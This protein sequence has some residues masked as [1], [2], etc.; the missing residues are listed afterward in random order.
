MKDIVLSKRLATAEEFIELRQSVGW[1]YPEKE[2]ISTGL[3]N[4]LFSVCAEIDGKIIGHGRIIGD[5]SFALYI[6]DIIIKPEYQR[7]GLGM[8]IMNE[9]MKHISEKY[10]KGTMVGLMAAKGKENFYKKFEFIER[11][12]EVYG[13]GMMQYTK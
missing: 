5:G 13:A 4:S 8:N 10:P 3:K 12:D 1:G 7:S 2:V 6:Q 9:I 11:P